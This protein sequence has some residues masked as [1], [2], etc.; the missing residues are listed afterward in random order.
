MH[1]NSIDTYVNH[2]KHDNIWKHKSLWIYTIS[3]HVGWL[4]TLSHCMEVIQNSGIYLKGPLDKP[5]VGFSLFVCFQK[6]GYPKMDGLW[7]KI[8]FKWMIWGYHYFRKPS[9]GCIS[10]HP[11]SHT[12]DADLRRRFSSTLKVFT[13]I[14]EDWMGRMVYL[15]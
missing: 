9:F 12:L 14:P 7:W 3:W 2:C 11:S 10:L 8:P 5:L 15:P 4:Y 6:L 1:L 13:I